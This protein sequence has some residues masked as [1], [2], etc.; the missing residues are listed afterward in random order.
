VKMN[1]FAT[2][3]VEDIDEFPGREALGNRALRV[4]DSEESLVTDIDE[5]RMSSEKLIAT[6]FLSFLANKRLD[7]TKLKLLTVEEQ[8]SLKKEFLGD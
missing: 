7:M 6:R 3:S 1:T 5:Q 2:N 4:I 8:Q